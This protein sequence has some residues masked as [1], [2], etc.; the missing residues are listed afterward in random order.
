MKC[1]NII[2]ITLIVA[3]MTSLSASA[4]KDNTLT[5]A[6]KKDG[7][8]LLFD[9]KTLTGWKMYQSKTADCWA[10]KNGELFCKGSET[11]KSDMRADIITSDK[12]ANFEL[13]V[14]W[15]IPPGG[16]SGIMYHVTEQY[17]AAYLSG[18]EYQ[19]IDD[20]GYAGGK[21]EDWQKTG[22][23]YAMYTAS[24]RPAKAVGQYN[25]S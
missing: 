12:Y 13:S 25:T 15:K 22:C 23:D 2:A 8:K 19:L 24:S 1:K 14:D 20:D 16:N 9:G 21:L 11:D 10:A 6:E 18:P 4:Q 17:E 5:A 3:V 7:W